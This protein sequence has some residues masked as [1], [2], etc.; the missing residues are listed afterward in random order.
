MLPGTERRPVL[1]IYVMRFNTNHGDHVLPDLW[2]SRGSGWVPVEN[3]PQPDG[4]SIRV[5]RSEPTTG[6]RGREILWHMGDIEPSAARSIVIGY[7][8]DNG[9]EGDPQILN[10]ALAMMQ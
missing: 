8:K 9:Y 5:G 3:I 7:I 1:G 6:A 10:R 2:L 4:T